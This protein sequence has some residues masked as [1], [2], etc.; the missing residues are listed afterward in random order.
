M[1]G[2]IVQKTFV[3]ILAGRSVLMVFVNVSKHNDKVE[4]FLCYLLA[5]DIFLTLWF[6]FSE[7]LGLV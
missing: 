1:I 6:I 7:Y 5:Y 4:I 2:V 3:C